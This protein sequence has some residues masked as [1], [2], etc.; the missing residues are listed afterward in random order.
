MR[1][2][3]EAHQWLTADLGPRTAHIVVT[4]VAGGVGTTTVAA[5]LARIFAEARPGRV[6]LVDERWGDLPARAGAAT[7]GGS[8]AEPDDASVIIEDAGATV[9]VPAAKPGQVAGVVP[10]VVAPW[11]ADGRALADRAVATMPGALT[12]QVDAVNTSRGRHATGTRFALRYASEL[13]DGGP[14]SERHKDDMMVALAVEALARAVAV[15]WHRR[16]RSS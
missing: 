12:V 2:A 15:P 14:V 16:H 8:W 1:P 5:L 7:G 9:L 6:A 11:H 3:P 10:V 13:A 4:G